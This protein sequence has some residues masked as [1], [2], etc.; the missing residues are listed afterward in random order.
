MEALHLVTAWPVEHVTAAVVTAD[1]AE[2][3]GDTERVYRLASLTKPMVAWAVMGIAIIASLLRNGIYLI[4]DNAGQLDLVGR[5]E[6]LVGPGERYFDGIGMLP[7]RLEPT[8]LWLDRFN[9]RKTWRQQENS[10]AYR[11]FANSSPKIILWT[12][13][14]NDIYPVVLPVIRNSYIKVSPNI[15]MAGLRLNHGMPI[16]FDVPVGGTYAL[17]GTGGEPLP[18]EVEIEGKTLR[19]PVRL[20]RGSKLVTLRSG[21]DSALLL[22]TGSYAGILKA[23]DDDDRLFADLYL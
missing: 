15:W 8:T 13:R 21:P 7:N 1:G 3:I 17:Y 18:G 11:V 6:A 9:I 12:Y 4:F 19:L 20:E 16:R 10:E 22:P 23:G 14:M 2:T 5:A